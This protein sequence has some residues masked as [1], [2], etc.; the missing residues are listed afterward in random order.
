MDQFGLDI[1]EKFH[2]EYTSYI[3]AAITVA[4]ALAVVM[5]APTNSG[6]RGSAFYRGAYRGVQWVALNFRHARNEN[7]PVIT[8]PKARRNL[9]S[10]DPAVAARARDVINNAPTASVG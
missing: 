10:P 6:I 4:A 8:V 2:P 1:F 5:P 3:T 7:D 9:D